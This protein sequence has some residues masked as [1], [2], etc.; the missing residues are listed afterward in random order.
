MNEPFI[1]PWIFYLIDTV[2]KLNGMCWFILVVSAILFIAFFFDNRI[3]E[4][5]NRVDKAIFGYNKV[6]HDSKLWKRYRKP[7]LA[8]MGICIVFIVVIPSHNTMYKMLA[9]HYATPANMERLGKTAE[10]VTRNLTDI[11]VD[12]SNRI[13]QQK[14]GQ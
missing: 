11:I 7:L 1:S 10:S 13:E 4:E 12:A 6:I 14:A 5:E 9:A 2:T 8:I 3:A